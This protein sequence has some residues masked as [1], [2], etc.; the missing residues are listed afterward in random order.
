MQEQVVF[1]LSIHLIQML[2]QVSRICI[3]GWCSL[4]LRFEGVK[5]VMVFSDVP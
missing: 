5:I 4:S 1:R 2:V 3:E